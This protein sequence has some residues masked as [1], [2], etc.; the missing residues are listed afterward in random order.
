[1]LITQ[2]RGSTAGM[3]LVRLSPEPVFALSAEVWTESTRQS[4]A[5]LPDVSGVVHTT[6]SEGPMW[7][8]L[9]L[10]PPVHFVNCHGGEFDPDWSGQ[11]AS[12]AAQFPTALA[13][14]GL[15]DKVATGMVV[16]VEACYGAAHW[17]PS[18]ANGHMSAAMMYLSLGAAGVFGSSTVAYGPADSTDY[19]DTLCS[20]FVEQVLGGASLGRAALVARQRYLQANAPLDLTDVKTLAQF[21]LLGDPSRVAFVAVAPLAVSKRNSQGKGRS[22]VERGRNRADRQTA[23]PA[24]STLVLARR[25]MLDEIGAGLGRTTISCAGPVRGSLTNAA[26]AKLIGRPV[27]KRVVIRSFRGERDGQ[28]LAASRTPRAHVAFV[29]AGKGQHPQ[30]VVVREQPS[31]AREVRVSVRR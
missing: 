29:P 12:G 23:T 7:S 30:L 5:S 8:K 15:K 24:A 22:V 6:P 13:A 3:S 26:L 9:D 20:L 18:A 4:I 1:V 10:A 21:S 27:G 16:A 31:G 17:A 25:E 2:L 28:R 14:T 19:A 11:P